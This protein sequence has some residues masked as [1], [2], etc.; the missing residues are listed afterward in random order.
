M[1]DWNEAESRHLLIM[2][3]LDK[4]DERDSLL[5]EARKLLCEAPLMAHLD[6]PEGRCRCEVCAWQ[7]RMQAF[8]D[9]LEAHAHSANPVAK[10]T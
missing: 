10:E 1:T 3:A 2:G 5:E 7:R 4:M 9:K 6:T 8:D